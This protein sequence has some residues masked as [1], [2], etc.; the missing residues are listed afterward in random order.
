[1]STKAI[2]VGWIEE[3]EARPVCHMGGG[4]R[5]WKQRAARSKAASRNRSVSRETLKTGIVRPLF[6]KDTFC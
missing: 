1:M 6:S 3:M 5:A 2:S 4:F